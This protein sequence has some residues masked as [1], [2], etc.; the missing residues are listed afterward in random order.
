MGAILAGLKIA[1][2]V[3]SPQKDEN[4]TVEG[5]ERENGFKVA[6]ESRPL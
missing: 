5:V 4:M 6:K 2:L 3:F 1:N